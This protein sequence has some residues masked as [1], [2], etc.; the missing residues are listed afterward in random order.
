MNSKFIDSLYESIGEVGMIYG[1]YIRPSFSR[2]IALLGM[3]N[4]TTKFF[5]EKK[6]L[7]RLFFSEEIQGRGER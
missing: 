4:A 7:F 6:L 2:F 3:E 1:K 5:A